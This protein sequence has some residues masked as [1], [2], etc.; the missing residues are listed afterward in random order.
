EG[1]ERGVSLRTRSTIDGR[2]WLPAQSHRRQVVRINGV[3]VPVPEQP[4]YNETEQGKEKNQPV[5]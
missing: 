4:G 3:G 2:S 5:E 1:S